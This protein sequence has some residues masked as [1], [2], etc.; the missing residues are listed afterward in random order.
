MEIKGNIICCDNF[1][2]LRISLKKYLENFL[3]IHLYFPITLSDKVNLNI[4]T[5]IGKGK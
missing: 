4:N 1:Q 5:T 2:V 3:Y